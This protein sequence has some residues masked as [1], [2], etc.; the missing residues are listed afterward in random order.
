MLSGVMLVD[1][2]EVDFFP[3]ETNVTD[4]TK[5]AIVEL[6]VV[7]EEA[8]E[9]NAEHKA[10]IVDAFVSSYNSLG[11]VF[12]DPFFRTL[13]GAQVERVAD[14]RD[15]NSLPIEVLAFGGCPG[16]DPEDVYIYETPGQLS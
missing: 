6:E 12:C 8:P 15:G 2:L 4:F 9:L 7:C 10:S 5:L 3:C 1:V 11:D 16:C 13:T 14:I